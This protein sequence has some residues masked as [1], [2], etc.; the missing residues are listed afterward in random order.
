M[1]TQTMSVQ[2]ALWLT[3][4]R[5]NNLMVIDSVLWL[6][7][8]LDLED[9]RAVIAERLVGRFPV[10]GCRPVAGEHGHVWEEDPDFD[11]ERHTF[12]VDLPR[13]VTEDAV[14]T[15]LSAQKSI[16]LDRDYPLWQM[17]VIN[18]IQRPEGREGSVVLCRF[19]HSIADGIRLTQVL[20]ALCDPEEDPDVAVT[21]AGEA[22]HGGVAGTV[23]AALHG[24]TAVASE[25]VH[26]ATQAVAHP[27]DTVA[28]VPGAVAHGARGAASELLG[29]ALHPHRLVD[30]FTAARHA[31]LEGLN[32]VK[33]VYKLGMSP[34]SAETVWSG[35]PGVEKASTW[36]PPFDLGRVKRIGRAEGATVN[37]V[38][39]AAV[40]GTL[41]RYVA[42]H[43][44]QLDEVVW[45]VPVSL[46]AF[47]DELPQELGNHF[48]LVMLKLPLSIEDP[49]ELLHEVS[50]RMGRIKHSHEPVIT[51]G[52]QRLISQSPSDVAPLLVNF[53]ADKALGVLTNVPGPRGAITFA[54]RRVENVLG[55]APCSG[56]Q[57]MT[58][59]LFT[60]NDT[61]SVTFGADRTLVPD[62]EILPGCY[63]DAMAEMYE[64]IVGPLPESG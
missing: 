15:Y 17:H 26:E 32:D 45:M 3:M 38:L 24:A 56:S 37:D 14:R 44:A 61:V 11:L 22:Y 20:L 52:L 8:P 42:K 30:V 48:A 1:A 50:A 60:Y 6:S 40:A 43:G 28:H 62:F 9:S 29:L 46:M 4:D 49:R 54:G 59:G 33:S 23:G 51:F 64:A 10:F 47:D 58:I 13:P 63:E 55:W 57:P 36:L 34:P 12:E 19:H 18:G 21:R 35:P 53:F 16:P 2:D 41:R 27:I 5:P 7:E 31:D 39:M 25:L